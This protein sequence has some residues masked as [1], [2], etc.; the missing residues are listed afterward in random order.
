M[1]NSKFK[2]FNFLF[3]LL[4]FVFLL[5]PSQ[6]SAHIL[7][8]DQNIGA[9]LHVDP[10]D[11]PIVGQQSSFFFEFKD[12][13]N[14]FQPKNCICIFSILEGGKNIFS[15]SLFQDNTDPNLSSASVFYTF[16]QKDVYKIQVVGRPT[17]PGE[18]QSFTLVYDLRVER[19]SNN[20]PS[21]NQ[22]WF[23]THIIHIIVALAIFVFVG[24]AFAFQ[25]K[26]SQKSNK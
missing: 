7:A 9:V 3:V 19:E 23:S 13:Q 16:P 17:T 25:M 12:K 5:L 21:T 18:F 24:V 11:D 20:Q 8:T 4:A 10:D 1:Q 14:K 2:T 22:N 15:Q 26:K 6:A